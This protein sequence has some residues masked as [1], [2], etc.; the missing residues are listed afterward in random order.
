MNFINTDYLFT[1][2]AWK[3]QIMMTVSNS[4]I[5]L[6]SLSKIMYPEPWIYILEIDEN[7]WVNL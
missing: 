1:A 4:I 5:S 7:V 2:K 3:N 6:I